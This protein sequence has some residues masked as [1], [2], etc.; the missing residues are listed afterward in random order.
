MNH[1]YLY[2][3]YGSVCS[4]PQVPWTSYGNVY[5][6]RTDAVRDMGKI[7]IRRAGEQYE[8]AIHRA[9]ENREPHVPRQNPPRTIRIAPRNAHLENLYHD[10]PRWVVRHGTRNRTLFTCNKVS[11]YLP[12]KYLSSTPPIT[13]IFGWR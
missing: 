4:S 13:Y 12:T 6:A 11:T 8:D 5:N 10:L 9:E 2:R 3:D 1:L 7:S